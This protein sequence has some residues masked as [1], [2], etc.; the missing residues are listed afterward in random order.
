MND[1]ASKKVSTVLEFPEKLNC[2]MHKILNAQKD[3]LGNSFGS[4]RAVYSSK[5]KLE[6]LVIWAKIKLKAQF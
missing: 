2:L 5:I 6:T 1:Y 3:G 4:H